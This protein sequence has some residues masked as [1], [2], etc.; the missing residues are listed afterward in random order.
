MIWGADSAV[1]LDPQQA[2]PSARVVT[3][4]PTRGHV[5]LICELGPGWS[6]EMHRTQSLDYA[7]VL[8]GEINLTVDG[9]KVALQPGDVVVQR[10]TDHRWDNPGEEAALLLVVLI[11]GVFSHDLRELLGDKVHDVVPSPVK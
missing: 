4:P 3:P 6:S 9:T 5:C 10:G 7:V 8:K 11:G 1:T 2:D